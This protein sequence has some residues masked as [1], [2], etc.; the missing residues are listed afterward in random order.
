[1]ENKE[2]QNREDALEQILTELKASDQ[3]STDPPTT[4]EQQEKEPQD[5]SKKK[6]NGLLADL[7][8][9]LLRV[10][11]ISLILAI[12]LLV[13]CGVTVNSGNRMAPAFHDRDVVIFY[14]LAKDIQAGEAVVYRGPNG[15]PLLGRVVAKGGD[16]VDIDENG[17]R[18]NGYYQAEPYRNGDTV[19]FE[20]GTALPVTL[21]AGEY[22]VLCD[23]RSQGGDSRTFGPISADRILGRVMLT[24]RQRD[25]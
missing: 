25:F 4:R 5:H 16:E 8:A 18:V 1:M 19:L 24:I 21:R 3:E 9:L 17:L 11:W 7:V 14:R 23:D 12:L 15:Q 6:G 22:F 2:I 10:G 13:I 20:G